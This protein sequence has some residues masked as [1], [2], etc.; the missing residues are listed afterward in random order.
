MST[1]ANTLS[2]PKSHT[3]LTETVAATYPTKINMENKSHA[4]LPEPKK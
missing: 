2:K 1:H 4:K 3:E